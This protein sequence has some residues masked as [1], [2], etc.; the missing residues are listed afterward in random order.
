[1]KQ[2]IC[3]GLLSAVA[4][5]CGS[6]GG[7]TNGNEGEAVRP[8]QENGIWVHPVTRERF[9]GSFSNQLDPGGPTM[10]FHIENGLHHGKMQ[11]TYPGSRQLK[12]ERTL[13]RGTLH[14]PRLRWYPNGRKMWEVQ[15][16]ND[17]I[18]SGK[19]YHLNGD[20]ASEVINGQGKLIKFDAEGREVET[21]IIRN[22]EP[23]KGNVGQVPPAVLQRGVWL[24]TESKEPFTGELDTVRDGSRLKMQLRQGKPHGRMQTWYVTDTKPRE[25][26][27]YWQGKRDGLQISW[28]PNGKRMME[29]EFRLGELLH[30]KTWR[31]D[32]SIAST[33]AHGN[34]SLILFDAEGEPRRHS[35]YQ[36]GRRVSSK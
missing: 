12:E 25:D 18:V 35:V 8:V 10:T 27:Y 17:R 14:G 23:Q 13:V 3:V 32:G 7:G 28:Y 34:G 36:N 2:I 26:Y 22:G 1:M 5:G 16:R 31:L 4:I 24:H 33:V 11:M 6:T 20:L 30:A 9:T 15:Y 29:A 19:S 21:T